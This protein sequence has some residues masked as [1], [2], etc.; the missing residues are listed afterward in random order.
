M[1][2]IILT[3]DNAIVYDNQAASAN[4]S[5]PVAQDL[6]VIPT[7]IAEWRAAGA[8][9]EQIGFY[10]QTGFGVGHALSADE[11]EQAFAAGY[12]RPAPTPDPSSN[13]V[14]S[15]GPFDPYAHIID[16]NRAVD[17]AAIVYKVHGGGGEKMIY[18]PAGWTGFFTMTVTDGTGSVGSGG[19]DCTLTGPQVPGLTYH[20]AN[21]NSEV[22]HTV[23][24]GMAQPNNGD[25]R[26]ATGEAGAYT[27]TVKCEGEASIALRHYP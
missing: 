10:L 21:G 17:G 26:A 20:A 1:P 8:P 24:V 6:K 14:P 2:H 12:P 22:T 3:I 4:S 25:P 5:S 9:W 7:K 16:W 19:Y 13:P 23:Y 27:Y 15:D 18:V 11:W